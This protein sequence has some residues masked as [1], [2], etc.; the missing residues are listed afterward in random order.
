[1]ILLFRAS[2][3]GGRR[4]D[5]NVHPCEGGMTLDEHDASLLRRHLTTLL[6]PLGPSPG[7]LPS[8]C[9]ASLSGPPPLGSLRP[10]TPVLQPHFAIFPSQAPRW[11]WQRVGYR[12]LTAT[13]TRPDT[14]LA[15]G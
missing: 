7:C 14:G 2:Q 1:V 13:T 4:E 11:L 8:G 3:L 12:R 10:K 15:G 9:R 6:G 5:Q